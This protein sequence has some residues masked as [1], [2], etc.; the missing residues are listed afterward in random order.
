MPWPTVGD[1]LPRA[2][3]AYT[4]LVKWRGWI[5]A[6]QHHGPDWTAVFGAVDFESIWPTLI[7]AIL[8]APALD[9]REVAEG[10]RSCRVEVWMTLNERTARVR[11]V[12]HYAHDDDAPRLV[13]AFP[14][15]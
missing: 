11:S 8:V 12:W 15:T 4:T 5:L 7:D 2:E 14:T 1:P 13:T 6:D 9:V 3:D 10:G